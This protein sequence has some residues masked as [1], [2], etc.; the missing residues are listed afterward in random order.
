MVKVAVLSI[1]LMIVLPGCA[2]E[3]GSQQTL[4]LAI[5]ARE[6]GS[7]SASSPT[8][9]EHI[10]DV[11]LSSPSKQSQLENK[12]AGNPMFGVYGSGGK[13]GQGGVFIGGYSTG[14]LRH[15]G[16]PGVVI[17]LGLAGHTPSHTVDGV[18]SVNMQPTFYLDKH[19]DDS[20]HQHAFV[21]VSGGYTRFFA[22]GNAA[23]YGGGLIWRRKGSGEDFADTRF[24]YR[25]YYITGFGLQQ[26]VRVSWAWGGDLD[27]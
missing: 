24:E 26:E 11:P 27:D 12:D 19:P 8:T 22:T 6:S 23:N 3:S 16:L 2:Q 1:G 5:N 13:M 20:N 15:P 17:E 7:K 4:A 9:D 18:F 10:I 25:E 21:F 14:S